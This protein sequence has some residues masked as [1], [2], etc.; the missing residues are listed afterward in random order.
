MRPFLER[1][2]AL[3]LRLARGQCRG[4]LGPEANDVAHDTVLALLDL[5]RR[6]SFD[7]AAIANMEAYLRVVVRNVASRARMKAARAGTTGREDDV[8]ALADD[9]T[10][11]DESAPTPEALTA[12]AHDRRQHLEAVKA[13]LSPRDALAFAI[14]VEEGLDIPTTAERLGTN[15][16]NVYQM[17]HRI[18]RAAEELLRKMAPSGRLEPR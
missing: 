16:N 8:S 14:L 7:P 13:S 10:T 17:R 9:L 1:Y 5:H 6:G 11:I 15:A 12:D 18:L 4:G 3:I 2:G